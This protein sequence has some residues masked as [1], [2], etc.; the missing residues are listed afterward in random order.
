M[1]ILKAEASHVRLSSLK[2]SLQTRLDGERRKGAG[3]KDQG[4]PA[5]ATML[6]K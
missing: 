1:F 5:K 4:S 2:M 6:T 3:V